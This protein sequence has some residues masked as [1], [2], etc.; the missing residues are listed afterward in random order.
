MKDI[1][2][3][4]LVVGYVTNKSVNSPVWIQYSPDA[5]GAATILPM[6]EIKYIEYLGEVAKGQATAV[7]NAGTI[8]GF[9]NDPQSGEQFAFLADQPGSPA[10]DLNEIVGYTQ[11]WHLRDAMDINESGL[12]V[13]TCT[14]T[15]KETGAEDVAGYVA[16]PVKW[17]LN[18]YLGGTLAG[19]LATLA[20][21]I[22][23]MAGMAPAPKG[24]GQAW[25]S[26]T[27]EQRETL[28]SFAIS[29]LAGHLSDREA[30]SQIQRIAAA[31]ASR[32]LDQS[33]RL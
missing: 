31:A 13:G 19:L 17:N 14:Y 8:V 21:G 25:E 23:G 3:N 9:A 24:L 22:S 26:L 15:N 1:N 12:I 28:L 29:T 30:Q 7:N 18:P 16:T 20:N 10:A 27:V 2:V 32:A 6:N 5:Q 33:N 4:R 11:G